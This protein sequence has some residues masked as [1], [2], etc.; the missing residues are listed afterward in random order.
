MDLNQLRAQ[1]K[2][3][4]VTP[5]DELRASLY[6]GYLTA[7]QT[8]FAQTMQQ[9]APL[10][11]GNNYSFVKAAVTSASLLDELAKI[12]D[13]YVAMAVDRDM[14]LVFANNPCTYQQ[15]FNQ[16]ILDPNDVTYAANVQAFMLRFPITDHALQTIATNFQQNILQACGRIIQDQ[17]AITDLFDEYDFL[18]I[19]G[20]KEIESTGS[21]F[22]KGGKQVLILT[23]SIIYFGERFPISTQ[24]KLIY[25]PS[26]IE[27]DCLLVGDSSAVKS[28]DPNFNITASLTEIINGLIRQE[29]QQNQN[30]TLEEL[31]TYRILPRNYISQHPQQAG[32]ALPI[33]N[34]YGYIQYLAYTAPSGVSMYNYYPFGSSDFLIFRSQ[35]ESP[36]IRKFYRQMGQLMA[37]ACT[38]SLKDL[39][40][41]NVRAMNY[42]PHLIDLEISLVSTIANVGD[43]G[44]FVSFMGSILGGI[45]GEYSDSED[46][47][48]T[49]SGANTTGKL[50]YST[51]CSQN[52]TRIACTPSDQPRDWSHPMP[53]GY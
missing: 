21:D 22:H 51:R 53:T 41:Q 31:P 17:R 13:L 1:L 49:V 52:T 29:K 40:L 4:G 50:L 24:L 36:I 14:Q 11:V 20:L 42:M 48:Y 39:H 35:D 15:Y 34:A 12:L 43:T 18:T 38:F 23:F 6:L 9:N 3:L 2:Q 16:R 7:T 44:L 46:Y 47:E 5:H 33:R 10:G 19:T 32:V 27:V 37:I 25:K 26:D 45:N 8:F 30:S 28:A